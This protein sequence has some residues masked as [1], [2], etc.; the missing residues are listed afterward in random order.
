M[1]FLDLLGGMGVFRR[2]LERSRHTC[3]SYVKMDKYAN[4][5]EVGGKWGDR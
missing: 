3:V 4:W 1:I 2:G 5:L